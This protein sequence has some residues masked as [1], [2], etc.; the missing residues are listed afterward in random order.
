MVCPSVIIVIVIHRKSVSLKVY[1]YIV[2]V[3]VIATCHQ[4]LRIVNKMTLL[5]FED[6]SKGHECWKLYLLIGHTY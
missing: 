4:T 2:H 5:C 1:M 3:G 6:Q